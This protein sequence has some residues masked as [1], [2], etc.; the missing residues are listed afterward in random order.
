MEILRALNKTGIL[1]L[2]RLRLR[3]GKRLINTS[4]F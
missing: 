3:R 2:T 1:I 4:L